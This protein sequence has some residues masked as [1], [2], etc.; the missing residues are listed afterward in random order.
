MV[1]EAEFSAPVTV[2]QQTAASTARQK[3]D[4]VLETFSICFSFFVVL[5]NFLYYGKIFHKN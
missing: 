4:E 3:R 5:G 1:L 2:P